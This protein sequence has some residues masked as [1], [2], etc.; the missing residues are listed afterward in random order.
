MRIG[1][2]GAGMIGATVAKLWVNAGHDVLLASR[3]PEERQDLVKTLGPRATAG[4]PQELSIFNPGEVHIR[5]GFA[6][7][8]GKLQAQLMREVFIKQQ[9]HAGTATRSAP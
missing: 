1:I 6:V 4:T 5:R 9:L 2:V 3:H 8:T 7:V